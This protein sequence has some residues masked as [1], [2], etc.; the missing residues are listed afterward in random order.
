MYCI[1][2][3]DC[4]LVKFRSGKKDA[5]TMLIDCGSCQ[6]TREDFM[7]YVK[8]LAGALT[9]KTIHLLIVTHEHNDHVNGFDKCYDIFKGL[10]IKEAWFAWTEDPTDPNG[11]AAALKQRQQKMK[12]GLRNAMA[13]L[14]KQQKSFLDDDAHNAYKIPLA[15]SHAAFL[16]GLN[17]LAS[18]NLSDAEGQPLPGQPSVDALKYQSTVPASPAIDRDAAFSTELLTVKLRYKAPDGDTSKLLTFPLAAPEIPAFEKASTDFQFA[19]AVAAFGMKLRGSP[20]AGDIGWG[21][22]QKIVRGNLGEDPGSYRAEFLTLIEKASKL[23]PSG[24]SQE[25]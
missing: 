3:G 21:D 25:E 22:I 2:T 11:A 6:G 9:N 19:S 1:G 8:D 18:I 10:T 20:T 4:F 16:T 15:D 13:A 12:M 14:D 7:P 24:R 23:K 5:F 17:T